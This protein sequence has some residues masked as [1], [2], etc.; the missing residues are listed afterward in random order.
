MCLWPAWGWGTV[1][2]KYNVL[3]S[4]WER[5]WLFLLYLSPTMLGRYQAHESHEDGCSYEARGKA[6]QSLRLSCLVNPSAL[7]KVKRG[8]W[9]GAVSVS[10]CPT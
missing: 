4:L 10:Y 6:V 5:P 3:G 8:T 2:T 7:R 9:W 1:D